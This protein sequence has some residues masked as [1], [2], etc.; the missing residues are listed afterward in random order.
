MEGRLAAG[1]AH[2]T[3]PALQ[4]GDAFFQ[5]GHCRVRDPGVQVPADLQVEQAGSVVNRVEYV[6]R[7]LVDGDGPRTGGR[8]RALTGVQGAGVEAVLSWSTMVR[9]YARGQSA[10]GSAVRTTPC[11]PTGRGRRRTRWPRSRP[12]RRTA[13]WSRRRCGIALTG[14]ARSVPLP[15]SPG[16]W[17]GR[18]W[19]DQ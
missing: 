16:G 11:R 7:G 2:G 1:R 6:R 10:T 9:T 18:R 19:S 5:D 17:P 15:R 12:R 8:V 14:P 13:G 4:R 3:H